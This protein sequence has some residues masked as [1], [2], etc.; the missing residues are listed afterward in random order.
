MVYAGSATR[1]LE[2]AKRSGAARQIAVSWSDD[3]DM[4]GYDEAWPMQELQSAILEMGAHGMAALCFRDFLPEKLYPRVRA[5]MAAHA[6]PA[7]KRVR[8]EEP[9]PEPASAPAQPVS[10]LPEVRPLLEP[11]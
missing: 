4:I 2:T 11:P 1:T 3:G 10:E 6:L 9:V 8:G 5:T 7:V